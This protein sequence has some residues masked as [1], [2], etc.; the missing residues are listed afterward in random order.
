MTSAET[1]LGKLR[2][3][4]TNE[5][6]CWISIKL[7]DEAFLVSVD[8]IV[9][10]TRLADHSVAELPQSPPEVLGTLQLRQTLVPL[11]DLR[12]LLGFDSMKR[13]TEAVIAL[14]DAREQD[15]VNW[16]NELETSV[17]EGREFSL[18]TDPHACKFGKWYDALMGN[19]QELAAFTN[20][21]LALRSVL[22]AFDGPHQQ[23]HGLAERVGGMVHAGRADEALAVIELARETVLGSM[24]RLFEKARSL[25]RELR[26]P[27]VMVVD[28]DGARAGFLIDGVNEIGHYT[29]DAFD[30]MPDT[31]ASNEFT[32]GVFPGD[33]RTPLHV[34]LSA[35]ALLA[36]S[37]GARFV[38][39]GEPEDSAQAA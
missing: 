13:E 10:L 19:K 15:H 30:P 6:G 20:R 28:R 18:T 9:E 23:I 32:A 25:V 39:D 2:M 38:C 3:H 36:R 33:E 12:V 17:R 14:L 31:A 1:S 37:T 34:V 27:L 21:N 22:E 8:H 29:E 11:V 16:L 5:L 26:Q 24:M 4:D 35:S 7:S